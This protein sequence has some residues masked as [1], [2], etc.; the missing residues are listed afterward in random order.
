MLIEKAQ[1]KRLPRIGKSVGFKFHDNK[2]HLVVYNEFSYFASEVE[3]EEDSIPDFFVDMKLFLSIINAVGDVEVSIQETHIDIADVTGSS[4]K[5]P[6]KNGY[7][8][9]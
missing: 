2:C 9:P 3:V 6:K 7:S 8:L 1:I 4:F 5:L